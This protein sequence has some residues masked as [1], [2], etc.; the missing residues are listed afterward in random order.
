MS[1]CLYAALEI[2][3]M[4]FPKLVKFISTRPIIDTLR[5]YNGLYKSQYSGSLVRPHAEHRQKG[6][7]GKGRAKVGY[8]VFF[9]IHHIENL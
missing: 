2:K 7:E 3:I 5:L 8:L 6:S 1:V 9:Y 4:D